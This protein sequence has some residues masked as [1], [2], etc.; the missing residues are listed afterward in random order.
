LRGTNAICRIKTD[1]S[2]KEALYVGPYNSLSTDGNHLYFSDFSKNEYIKAP[3]NGGA[4]EVL[5][6]KQYEARLE[7]EW[8]YYK[9]GADYKLY[10][11]R[12]D[13]PGQELVEDKE[14]DKELFEM[15]YYY[16]RSK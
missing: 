1:G 13:G 8:I 14:T 9:D 4:C 12:P 6:E 5:I 3:M 10:R 7:E 11:I 15:F 2:G 16:K